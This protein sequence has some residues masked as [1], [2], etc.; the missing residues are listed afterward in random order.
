MMRRNKSVG[1]GS[2][3]WL[4]EDFSILPAFSFKQVKEQD[5]SLGKPQVNGNSEWLDFSIKI[6]LLIFF[7][8]YPISSISW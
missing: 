5:E 3:L 4:L 6:I 1:E 7:S 8:L 2:S